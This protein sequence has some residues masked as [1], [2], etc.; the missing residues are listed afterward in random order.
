ME[1]EGG[2]SDGFQNGILGNID[3]RPRESVLDLTGQIHHLPCCIKHDGPS[4]VSHYFKP[5]K[6]GIEVEVLTIEEACFRGRK[7]QGTTIS[8]PDGYSGLVLGKKKNPGK[9]KASEISEANLNCWEIGAKFQSITYW[10]HDSLPSQDD[11]F[12]RCFHW[13][14][15]ANALHKPITDDDLA[16]YISSSKVKLMGE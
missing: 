13:F 10:N 5:K 16:S 6:T 7:L 8:L 12:L 11:T 14:A 4:S 1:R 2:S 9:R 3:L 15:V